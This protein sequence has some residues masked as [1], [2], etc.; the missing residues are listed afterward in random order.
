MTLN[1]LLTIS[2][3]RIS[4]LW[5]FRV[6][7][8]NIPLKKRK[9]YKKAKFWKKN[10]R[11]WIGP[12]HPEQLLITLTQK[13]KEYEDIRRKKIK[14]LCIRSRAKWVEEGE[15]PSKYFINL[16]SRNYTCKIIPMVE[17]EDGSRTCSQVEIVNKTNFLWKIVERIFWIFYFSRKVN[18]MF[19][20]LA[21]KSQMLQNGRLLVLKYSI[22]FKNGKWPGP[23]GFNC[24]FLKLFWK[25]IGIFVT[26]AFNESY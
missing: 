10:S 7:Q 4:D 25:E 21:M 5:K 22:F 6:T 1:L 19:Q 3:F 2:S 15:K 13:Q 9:C 14:G 18:M 12:N 16:E 26:R 23:D 8:Y 17:R 11:S 20:N 24:E